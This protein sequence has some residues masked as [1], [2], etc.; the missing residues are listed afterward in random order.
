MHSKRWML[1][2]LVAA[3]IAVLALAPP[4]AT[5]AGAPADCAALDDLLREAKTDFPALRDRR[6]DR[7]KCVQRGKAF[8]CDWSFPTDTFAAAEGQAERLKTC[9]SVQQSAE[10]LPARR[11][12]TAFQVN[13]ETSVLVRGPELDSGSWAIRLQIRTT[14]DWD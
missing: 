8:R 9:I 7:A 1:R 10:P 13:P 11:G 4:P 3:S 5:A 2:P 6:F 12:E 14:A